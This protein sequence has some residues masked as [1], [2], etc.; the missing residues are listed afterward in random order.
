MPDYYLEKKYERSY[1]RKWG[2]LIGLENMYYKS[3]MP[4]KNG[5]FKC[6]QKQK[7]FQRYISYRP[8]Y[9]NLS[10]LKCCI[11]Q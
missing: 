6:Q 8:L 3:V 9:A 1:Y 2:N 7:K 5:S 10:C 11:A 4:A